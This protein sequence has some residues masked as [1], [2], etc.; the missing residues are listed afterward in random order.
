MTAAESLHQRGE[1]LRAELWRR[2]NNAEG[3]VN[4]SRVSQ[5]DRQRARIRRAVYAEAIALL[6][7]YGL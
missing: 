5:A 2:H 7:E 1:L 6:S 3:V 4:E